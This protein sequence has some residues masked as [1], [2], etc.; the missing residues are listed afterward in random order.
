MRIRYNICEPIERKLLTN[1]DGVGT[2]IET[3]HYVYI[4]FKAYYLYTDIELITGASQ[5]KIDQWNN[6]MYINAGSVHQSLKETKGQSACIRGL[7]YN[8]EALLKIIKE[9]G[10]TLEPLKVVRTRIETETI[11]NADD[12]EMYGDL[13]VKSQNN[14]TERTKKV[15]EEK[16]LPYI[17]KYT[18]YGLHDDYMVFQGKYKTSTDE[19]VF[20]Y[21]LYGKQMQKRIMQ[22]LKK[23]GV[24]V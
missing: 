20:R 6:E 8:P 7:I 18:G 11:R 21:M 13:R 4:G 17:K 5:E 1:G 16:E 19:I 14:T 23:H 2:V 15:T 12:S 9:R 24:D 22:Q 10:Y 3:Q